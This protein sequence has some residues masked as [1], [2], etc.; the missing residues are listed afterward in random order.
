VKRQTGPGGV[1]FKRCAVC[2]REVLSAY[3]GEVTAVGKG[4]IVSVARDGTVIGK[5]SCGKC[6]TWER[7]PVQ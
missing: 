5:C 7:E 3:R 4:E 6:V 2:H 1:A